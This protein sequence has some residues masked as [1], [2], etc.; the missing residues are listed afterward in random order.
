MKI[1]F[2]PWRFDY[3]LGKRESTC[4]FCRIAA[5]QDDVK[6]L[7][8]KRNKNTYTVLNR[9][10]YNNCHLM[11]IP[12]RHLASIA[13]IDTETGAEIMEEIR[14][15]CA[16][17]KA[18]VKPDGFN[19]GLNVGRAAGAG[20]DEHLHWHVVP[21]WSG[22]MNFMPVIGKVKIIPQSLE[23]AYEMLKL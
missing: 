18:V 5:E 22:D 14:F 7:I 19:I 2:A 17:L 11:V 10:P 20:I 9:Y 1:A 16:R 6:N 3:I 8:L 4:V 13:D 12:F 23:S 15:W 21:R